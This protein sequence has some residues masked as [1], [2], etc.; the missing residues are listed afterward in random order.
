VLPSLQPR[1]CVDSKNHPFI[2]DPLVAQIHRHW[3]YV[4][5]EDSPVQRL[6]GELLTNADELTKSGGVT[7]AELQAL[8]DEWTRQDEGDARAK[9]ALAILQGKV[10]L[11]QNPT[12]TELTK[13]QSAGTLS[14]VNA[15]EALAAY[16]ADEEQMRKRAEAAGGLEAEVYKAS[17][18]GEDP[19]GKW[20]DDAALNKLV[21]D[22]SPSLKAKF[23]A[24]NIAFELNANTVAKK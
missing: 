19:V 22:L 23:D 2:S 9:L 15:K 21:D 12:A 10:T 6:M 7:A 11:P 17:R 14:S 1:P 24:L 18:S 16:A 4:D 8:S 5:R 13:K 20:I 3:S